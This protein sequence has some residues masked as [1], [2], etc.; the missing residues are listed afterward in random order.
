MLGPQADPQSRTVPIVVS[1]S[2]LTP[3][4]RPGVSTVAE[5]IVIGGDEE[6]A[7]PL[8]A[9]AQDEVKKIIFRRDP[10]D[11]DHVIRI[12]A[13]IGIHDGKWVVVNSGLKEGD[14]VVLDGIY[15]LV[16][17]GSGQSKGGHFH[18]DGTWHADHD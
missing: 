9:V 17:S 18:A 8:A 1:I 6:L 3:W 14:E 10:D 16:L 5:I 11:R 13:D 2:T 15:E 7:I 4:A 12:D